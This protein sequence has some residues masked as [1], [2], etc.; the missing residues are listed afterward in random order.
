MAIYE[1]YDG[2]ELVNRIIA[3]TQ[4]IAEAVTG[5]TA[6]EWVKVDEPSD[7]TTPEIDDTEE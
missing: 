1:I 2:N 3:E 7:D 5:L 6:I 4:E